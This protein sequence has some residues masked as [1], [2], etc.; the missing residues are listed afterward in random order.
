MT[1]KAD[2]LARFAGEGDER[3]F[4]LPDLTLWY[5]WHQRKQSLPA[6]WQDCSLPEIARSMGVPGWL[7]ATP[8]RVEAPGID[9]TTSENEQERVI[10]AATST[11]KLVWRWQVGPDGDWWQTEYPV[12]TVDDLPALLELAQARIYVLD[13]TGL[14]ELESAAGDDGLLALEIPRRPY[15]ILLHEFLGWGDGLLLLNE[16][17]LDEIVAI[18]ET[19]TH[20]FVREMVQLP[21]QIILSPDN[22]DG[23]FISP[24]VFQAY[25]A[26]SYHLTADELHQHD[27][28]LLV[29][30]GGPIRH[31]LAPLAETGI[32]GLQGI[33]GLPQ[34]NASLIQA[35][36][37][38]GPDITLW[39]GIP[40]NFLL[41]THPREEFEA[42]VAQAAQDA[43]VDNRM[44][45]GIAD[46]VPAQAELS[47]L[48]AIPEL[49][50]G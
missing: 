44:I 32:D 9:I 8:W 20:E 38:T 45:L 30:V 49:V 18:L 2:I 29:H 41:D 19:K 36:G 10:I 16:P 46:R 31:L 24:P 39:G 48:E 23:Q 42:A 35:R 12:K 47:R 17:L 11:A 50:G 13:A 22:L 3:S 34:G 27:K 26:D 40:Q 6:K 28:Y 21:G 15:S 5:T 33:A 37:L 1:L 7:T 25:L 4:Y 43:A 14:A